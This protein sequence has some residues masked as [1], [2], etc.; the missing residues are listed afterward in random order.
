MMG[1]RARQISIE[2]TFGDI[3]CRGRSP[4]GD[5]LGDS[6]SKLVP[7]VTRVAMDVGLFH[8]VAKDTIGI[9]SKAAQLIAQAMV[10]V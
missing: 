5:C 6:I 7:T 4:H 2:R 8:V 10:S 3:G 9:M 1:L